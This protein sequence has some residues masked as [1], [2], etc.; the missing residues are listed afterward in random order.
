MD[1]MELYQTNKDFKAYVDKVVGNKSNFTLEEAL[2]LA[3][4]RA[5]AEYIIK[6]DA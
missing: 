3:I 4:V 5:Y 2:K 6:R 1:P